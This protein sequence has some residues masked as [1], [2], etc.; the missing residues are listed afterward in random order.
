M[1]GYITLLILVLILLQVPIVF[2]IGI[3]TAA[4]CWYNGID[5]GVIPQRTFVT[6]DVFTFL[7][8]PLFLL[9]GNLMNIGG[10]TQRLVDF[11]RCLVGH[12]SG[13]LGHANVVANMFMAGMSGSAVADAA[14]LGSIEIK[15]MTKAG[16][17]LA[18]SASLSCAAATIGP[19]IPPS[20]IMV[21]YSMASSTSIGRLF[22]GGV[23][24]GILMGGCLMAMVYV[25]SVRRKYPV[26]PWPGLRKIG[27]EF[28]RASVPLMTP[29]II[30]GGTLGGIFTPTES[31]AVAA[32]YALILGVF[33]YREI[34]WESFKKVFLDTAINTGIIG[35]IVGICGIFSWVLTMQQVPQ[36]LA[37]FVFGITQNKHL[38]LVMLNVI[39][40]FMGCFIDAAPMI[41]L[42]VPV[43]LP[44]LTT[45]GIDLVHFGIIICLNTA[46][47]MLTPPVGVC[48]YAVAAISNLSIEYLAWRMLP[49]MTMLVVALILITFIPQISLFLPNLVLK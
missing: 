34:T 49:F 42:V 6:L 27:R 24:P 30:L 39:F 10:V 29:I 4:L 38:I 17:D 40:L 11:S 32:V 8:I 3:G 2:S 5:L 18:F 13:G 16:Y 33:I 37:T 28:L 22:I 20:I 45:A 12:I 26:D 14:G 23:L 46:I 21:V 44:L 48:L 36:M 47:G 43:L 25:L 41:L 7:A 35:I 19:I 1:F 9:A 31:G 15:M